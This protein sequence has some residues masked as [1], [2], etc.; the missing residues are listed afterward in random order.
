[1]EA[2]RTT[3]A[4]QA[5]FIKLR[6]DVKIYFD[7]SSASRNYAIGAESVGANNIVIHIPSNVQPIAT[8]LASLLAHE[9]FHAKHRCVN[10][11]FGSAL[12]KILEEGLAVYHQYNLLSWS[13]EEPDAY[14]SGIIAASDEQGAAFYRELYPHLNDH[15]NSQLDHDLFYDRSHGTPLGYIVGFYLAD[16]AIKANPQFL[17][18][19]GSMSFDEWKKTIVLPVPR[20]TSATMPRHRAF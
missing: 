15:L 4:Y 18:Q 11:A 2:L 13:H 14:I 1:M 8:S 9:L 16:R 7:R 6:H 12:D 20:F 10:N 19:A 5:E 17:A 3:E